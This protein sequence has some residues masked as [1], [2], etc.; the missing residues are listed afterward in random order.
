VFAAGALSLRA[1][2][3]GLV[4]SV[5]VFGVVF[6]S[7][8]WDRAL[9]ASGG[10]KYALYV[11]KGLDLSTALKAGTLL[12][13]R[14]GPTGIVTV[15]RLTGHLSLAIDGKVD[16]STSSDMLTQ[17]TLAHL[18]LLLHGH[19]RRICIIGLGSGVTLGSALAH[20]ITGADV[21][22][23]SPEVVQASQLFAADNRHALDD[24][25]TRLII[26]HGPS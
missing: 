13:Y 21:V 9:L 6:S 4:S 12:Y 22:E 16:A 24:P 5:A 23:I 2:I 25:R 8:P 18:P 14:E 26:G 19:D 1:R 17:K 7:S 11:P 15:K 3:V 10:Y 20:P